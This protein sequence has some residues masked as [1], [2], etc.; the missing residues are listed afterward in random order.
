MWIYVLP[1]VIIVVFAIL[2][3]SFLISKNK[4]QVLNV[5]IKEVQN[6]IDE[7]LQKKYNVL[8]DIGKVI[9][10]KTKE[11]T[12]DELELTNIEDFSRIETNNIL[13]K[14]DHIVKE[15][16]EFNKSIKFKDAELKLFEEFNNINI[17]CLATE[18]YYN[19]NVNLYNKLIKEFPTSIIA[20]IKKYKPKEL[21][22]NEKE[23]IF[24]I[25]K[26]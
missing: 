12:F 25:L 13:A 4:L 20:K 14:Y 1:C 11:N 19:D 24:E 2:F 23:E 26:K 9:K 10:E 16:D 3:T 21:F 8:T 18:K 6:N 5:K 22:S 7:L 17:E 15:F